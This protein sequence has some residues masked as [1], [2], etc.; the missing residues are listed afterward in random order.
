MWNIQRNKSV[1]CVKV[2]IR[3]ENLCYQ[4]RAAN[5]QNSH[6][7]P[8]PFDKMQSKRL[9]LSKVLLIRVTFAKR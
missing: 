5:K 3:E 4:A 1:I 8:G 2:T 7:L 6:K 9:E